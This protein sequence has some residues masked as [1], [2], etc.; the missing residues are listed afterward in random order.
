MRCPR[1]GPKRQ[2]T[3]GKLAISSKIATKKAQAPLAQSER[4]LRFEFSKASANVRMRYPRFRNIEP[5]RL[6][7]SK[8][9][10]SPVKLRRKM[11]STSGFYNIK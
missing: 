1:I 9:T 7:A 2:R 5:A 4:S 8:R 11:G 3:F 6:S 10:T